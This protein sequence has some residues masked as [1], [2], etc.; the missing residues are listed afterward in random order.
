MAE[1]DGHTVLVR[2]EAQL[3]IEEGLKLT[4]ESWV[5]SDRFEF[6][7]KRHLP[8]LRPSVCG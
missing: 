2:E 1:N 7:Q 5:L 4:P 6:G 8:L 3:L